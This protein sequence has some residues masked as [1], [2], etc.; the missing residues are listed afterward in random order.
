[1]VFTHGTY[2]GAD[3][4]ERVN[5]GAV[6]NVLNALKKPARIALMTTIGVTKPTP[7][8]DWK[9]RGER[10]SEPAGCP[11][12]LSV[13]AGSTTTSRISTTS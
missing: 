2:G 4:A 3:E 13:P 8:H 10:L 12:R 1:M 6:R 9:R 5:Y 7:G 11:T